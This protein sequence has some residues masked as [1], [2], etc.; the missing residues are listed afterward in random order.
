MNANPA[1]LAREAFQPAQDGSNPPV[2]EKVK[3]TLGMGSESQ[4]GTEPVSGET[5]EGTVDQPFDQGNQ[6]GKSGAASNGAGGE[7][8]E[9]IQGRGLN[10]SGS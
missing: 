4:S 8:T 6:E 10:G 7:G 1:A 2:V 9:G 5:G 3:E